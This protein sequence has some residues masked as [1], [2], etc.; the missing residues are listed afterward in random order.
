MHPLILVGIFIVSS[1]LGYVL[2]KNVTRPGMADAYAEVSRRF[3]REM[4]E[5]PG[6]RGFEVL[7]SDQEPEVVANLICWESSEA[8]RADDGSTFLRFKPE[9]KPLFVS[10][11]TE[12]FEAL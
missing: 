5:L 12:T 8:V 4:E 3:G 10:D 7:R 2:I 6:C 9:L 1:V 11:T